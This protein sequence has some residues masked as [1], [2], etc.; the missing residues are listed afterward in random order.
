MINKFDDVKLKLASL[1]FNRNKEKT[2]SEVFS[3]I[4]ANN[5]WKENFKGEGRQFYS[6]RGSDEE[7]AI[8]YTIFLNRFI[9]QHHIHTI[10][11]LGCGDFRVGSTFAN[12]C[13][14]YIGIDCVKELIDY[15]NQRYGSDKINFLC[16]DITKDN[17]PQAD[18][19]LIRQVLQHLSNTDIEMVIQ[20]CLIYPYIVVTEHL[21]NDLRQEPNIDKVRGLHTRLFFGSGVYLDKKPFQYNIEKLL[22]IPYD[23]K[24]HL[25]ICLVKH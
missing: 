2:N 8:P 12:S 24:S 11:D 15:N 5:L 3:Q 22:E 23:D 10:V 14:Q 17:L 20:N 16:K 6:G 21:L 18:L 19:C 13:D 9:S 1:L 25:E 7:Y 4:Y